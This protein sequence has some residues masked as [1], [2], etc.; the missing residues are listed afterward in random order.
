MINNEIHSYS[1]HQTIKLAER[2]ANLLK[3]GDV[4]TLEGDL[5]AGKTTFTKGLASGLGITETV[6][7]PTFTMIKEYQG[8]LPLFH[9]DMYRMEFSDDDLGLAEYFHG[10]GICV[11]E[12]ADF[13][14]D[15][16]PKERLNIRITYAGDQERLL[17]FEPHGVH[18][19]WVV[20]ELIG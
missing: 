20:T 18:F 6:N 8:E 3:P 10:D 1:E 7:S 17:Y 11:V 4:L 16:L 12:W 13:V 15:D 14:K 2:L 5:G 9:M 19:H